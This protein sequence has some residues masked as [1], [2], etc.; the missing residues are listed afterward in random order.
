MLFFGLGHSRIAL[1]VHLTRAGGRFTHADA[2]QTLRHAF[3]QPT[4]ISIH[5]LR[6]D[7]QVLVVFELAYCCIPL[8]LGVTCVKCSAVQCSAVQ[9]S[10]VQCSAVQCGV[11]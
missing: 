3:A 1:A 6:F 8:E 4:N 5:S 7:C 2:Y 11:V 10:A 9:C